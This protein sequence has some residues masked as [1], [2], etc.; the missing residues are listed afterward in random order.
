L[1]RKRTKIFCVVC[2]GSWRTKT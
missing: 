2:L 1:K